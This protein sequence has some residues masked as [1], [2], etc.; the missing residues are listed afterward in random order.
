[1]YPNDIWVPVDKT[2]K[3][4]LVDAGH[5]NDLQDHAAAIETELGTLIKGSAADLKTRLAVS[6]ANDGAVAKGTSF[7]G[8]P[9]AFQLFGRTDEDILYYR[10]AA[11][12]GWLT[13]ITGWNKIY[14]QALSAVTSV[15]ISGLN[16]DA[17][18][19][20]MLLLQGSCSYAD[21][22][23][24]IFPNNDTVETNYRSMRHI[25]LSNSTILMEV[26]SNTNG[27]VKTYLNGQYN[28]EVIISAMT[29]I[30]RLMNIKA[31]VSGSLNSYQNNSVGG[32]TAG[33]IASLVISFPAAF[34][35]RIILFGVK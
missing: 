31:S 15:T 30:E 9:V 16:G 25:F 1:M 33:N 26:S 12:S 7:P 23:I 22:Y 13:P 4:D 3:V 17:E 14:D 11:N 20:Y 32:G 18:K 8:S 28:I 19:N 5:I 24:R 29:G 6:L 10:N 35:G 27:I 21:G 34:T 2:N